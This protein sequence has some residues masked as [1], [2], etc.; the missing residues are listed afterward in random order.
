MLYVRDFKLAA[1]TIFSLAKREGLCPPSWID[2]QEACGG[3]CSSPGPSLQ[4]LK[5]IIVLPGAIA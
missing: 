3:G 4:H 2:V 5:V 1:L